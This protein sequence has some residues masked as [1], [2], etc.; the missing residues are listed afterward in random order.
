MLLFFICMA[1]TYENAQ[2]EN[3]SRMDLFC[4]FIHT[5]GFYGTVI[6]G[7]HLYLSRNIFFIDQILWDVYMHSLKY[8]NIHVVHL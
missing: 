7:W 8:S 3:Y 5:R 6:R 2:E 4:V 1:D